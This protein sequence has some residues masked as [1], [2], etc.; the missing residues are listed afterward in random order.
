MT[1]PNGSGIVDV[2]VT[3][4]YRLCQASGIDAA[5]SSSPLVRSCQ[6]ETS[7]L[8]LLQIPAG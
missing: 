6:T 5:L 2:P 4:L 7:H 8:D 1:L 3:R